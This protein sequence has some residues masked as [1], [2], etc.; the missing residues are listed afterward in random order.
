MSYPATILTG[1]SKGLGSA[2]AKRLATKYTSSQYLILI[3]RTQNDQISEPEYLFK[4]N[5]IHLQMDLSDLN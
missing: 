3:S 1:A 2:L 4:E 5:I